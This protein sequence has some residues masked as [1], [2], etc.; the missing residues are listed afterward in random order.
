SGVSAAANFAIQSYSFSATSG[1]NGGVSCAYTTNSVSTSCSA[2]YP[3]G[4]QI[5]V[6]AAPSAGYSLSSW[7]CSPSVC[8]TTSSSPTTVT[9]PAQS[10]T[11]TA[12]FA[13]Q[14]Y[15]F[16]ATV[17]GGGTVS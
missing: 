5:T 17:G 11:V 13:L 9:I 4:T 16:S 14:S 10:T 6:T 1:G 8:S 12:N 2:S 15:S 7:T 3:Y